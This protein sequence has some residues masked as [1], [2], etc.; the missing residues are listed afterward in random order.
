MSCSGS[1]AMRLT[2]ILLPSPRTNSS[3][4]PKSGQYFAHLISPSSTHSVRLKIPAD[5]VS[6]TCGPYVFVEPQNKRRQHAEETKCTRTKA[7]ERVRC[8]ADAKYTRTNTSYTCTFVLPIGTRSMCGCENEAQET[9]NRGEGGGHMLQQG[10]V[11]H[12][13]D[14]PR[15]IS[16]ASAYSCTAAQAEQAHLNLNHSIR[17]ICQNCGRV[18]LNSQ[19]SLANSFGTPCPSGQSY[20]PFS[21]E[22]VQLFFLQYG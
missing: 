4:S 19:S 13:F 18:S 21:N 1:L 2:K 7:A 6:H 3:G 15:S 17:T 8:D 11:R 22:Y 14:T 20:L 16:K 5:S 12:N 10:D 9:W